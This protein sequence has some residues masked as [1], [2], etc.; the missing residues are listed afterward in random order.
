MTKLFYKWGCMGSGKSLD[1]IRSVYNYRERGMDV[2][3]F[4]PRIDTRDGSFE[5][6]ITSRT[7]AKVQAEWLSTTDNIM[8]IIHQQ[9]ERNN[10]DIKAIFIDEVQFCTPQQIE[11]ISDVVTILGIPVLAYGLKTDF[12]GNLFP[13]IIK[14]FELADDVQELRSICWCGARSTQNGRI[15]DGNIVKTGNQVEIG[16]NDKYISLCTKHF[17]E[18][19]L[20]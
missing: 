20:S 12:Q 18:G 17:K 8:L 11:Q 6:Y 5:C 7:G 3:V 10:Q 16:G 9:I 1:L 15:K 13:S 19:K 4:K 14:M 2:L